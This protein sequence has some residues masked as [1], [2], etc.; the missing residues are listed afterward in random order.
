LKPKQQYGQK[1]VE[2]EVTPKYVNSKIKGNK[3]GTKK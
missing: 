1:S 2:S 3:K